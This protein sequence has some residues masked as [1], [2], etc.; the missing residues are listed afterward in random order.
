M[1][2]KLVTNTQEYIGTAAERAA[3]TTA[4]VYVGSTFEETDTGLI[5]KWSGS[6]WFVSTNETVAA[7]MADGANVTLGAKADA[8]AT[9]GDATPWSVIALL[10]GIFN[11]LGAVV[12]TVTG[13]VTA[14]QS[15]T[16]LG[17]T[18]S[19]SKTRPDNATP[20]SVNDVVG[21]D[22]ATNLE[23]TSVYGVAGSEIIINRVE[24]RVDASA[25]PAGVAG[26]RLHLYNAAPTAITDNL[27]FNLPSADRAKYL[28][29]IPI[30]TPVDLGDT[31]YVDM[32]NVNFQCKLASA[33]TTLYAQFT[34]DNI[35]TP[36]N[37]CVKTITIHAL[38]V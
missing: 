12:A 17:I 23:F 6:A 22:P 13:T 27:A 5:Y 9:V 15:S 34:T 26:F 29:W 33:S 16:Q 32:R 1:A 21:A 18:S 31:L 3:M 20:Y 2:L 28:G 38:G 25:L 35:F 24:M 4:G 36:T 37:L 7:T 19:A 30:D 11:K 10:K 14:V 8:A